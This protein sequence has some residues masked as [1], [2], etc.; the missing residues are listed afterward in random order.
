MK[1]R[2]LIASVLTA[3]LVVFANATVF[4]Q[5]DRGSITGTVTDQSGAVV[6]NAKVTATSLDTGAVPLGAGP[7]AHAGAL[8]RLRRSAGL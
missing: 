4:A 3:L 6:Q 1:S 8:P 2:K 7:A 5:S